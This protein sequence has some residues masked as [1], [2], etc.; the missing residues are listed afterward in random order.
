M[1]TARQYVITFI[2]DMILIFMYFF[3]CAEILELYVSK[4]VNNLEM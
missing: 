3:S 2:H 1:R 4:D